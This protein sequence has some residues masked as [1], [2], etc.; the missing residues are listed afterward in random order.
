MAYAQLEKV[1]FAGLASAVPRH[2]VSNLDCPPE[3]RSERERLV[4]NIGIAHRRQSSAEVC[5][6]DLAQAAAEQLIA[7]LGWRKDEIDALLVVTQSPDY[8][9]PGTG[10]LLQDRLGLPHSCLAFDINL[11][12]SGYPYGLFVAGSMLS[13]GRLKK[14]LV[15]VGDKSTNPNSKDQGFAVLFS[16][17]ATAT[18]LEYDESAPPMHFDMFSDGA[19]YQAIYCPA[20]GNRN[21]IKPEHLQETTNAE[22][23]TRRAVDIVLDG[24]AILNFSI[25]R[26]PPAVQALLGKAGAE[27]EQID[28]FFFH[29]ANRMINETIR[30]KLRLPEEKVPTTLYDYGNTSSASIP[31]TMTV[32][33][34]EA[35]QEAGGR[36][37][38]M[39]G[40]GVGLSWAS[41]ILDIAG[42]KMLPLVEI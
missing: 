14:V 16:D 31:L 32:H 22:G 17:A 27:A 15:L 20:G 41:A 38:L 4:R 34:R 29:Q 1:R 28:Y 36:K 13:A 5:F 23:I 26:I 37:V 10:I 19:G 24:P 3:Q 2:S 12:C 30:K 42:A 25:T 9:Y 18:A 33:A 11:G 40:F 6:S 39:S 7:E 8:P 21:P 35:L